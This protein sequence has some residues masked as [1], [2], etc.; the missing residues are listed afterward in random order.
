LMFTIELPEEAVGRPEGLET[1]AHRCLGH[2]RDLGGWGW[3]D[4]VRVER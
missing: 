3:R 2:D 4:R 1:L